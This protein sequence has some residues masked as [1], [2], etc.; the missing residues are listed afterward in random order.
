MIWNIKFEWWK[1]NFSWV[2]F[3]IERWWHFFHNCG[4]C[5]SLV[6]EVNIDTFIGISI[7][8]SIEMKLHALPICLT[9]L[10]Y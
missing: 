3:L 2:T 5:T 9:Q 7:E 1:S 10:G 4:D 8:I 6:Y